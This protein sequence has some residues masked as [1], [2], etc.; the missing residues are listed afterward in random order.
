MIGGRGVNI[1]PVFVARML[2]A[3]QFLFDEFKFGHIR[4]HGKS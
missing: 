3:L 1:A 2:G 4:C